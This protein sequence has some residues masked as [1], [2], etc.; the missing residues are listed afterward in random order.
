M[1]R[2]S[3]M[4]VEGK[5]LQS[6]DQSYGGR[7]ARRILITGN[8]RSG[9]HTMADVFRH[10]GLRVKHEHMGEDG[11]VSCFFFFPATYMPLS[12]NYL[13]YSDESKLPEMFNDYTFAVKV[14][15]VR[16][17]LKCIRS[18][19]ELMGPQ[20]QMWCMYHGIA[21]RSKSKDSKLLR[22]M[23]TWYNTN[24]I[25]GSYADLRIRIE[26]GVKGVNRVC[27]LLGIDK[28]PHQEIPIKNPVVLGSNSRRR[29]KNKKPFTWDELEQADKTMAEKIHKMARIY[30]Y[31]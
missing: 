12:V 24:K 11:T 30:R 6:C 3:Y 19:F 21:P 23:H 28:Y 17:P 15:L 31:V 10:M 14:H 27:K 16:D 9:S 5:I 20:H 13:H 18:M 1:I 25:I 29:Y 4:G 26:D 8:P 22:V 7:I 2:E